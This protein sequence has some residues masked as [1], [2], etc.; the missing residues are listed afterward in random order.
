VLGLVGV[1]N[2][3]GSVD[4]ELRQIEQSIAADR[5]TLEERFFQRKYL[6]PILLAVAIAAFNQLSGINAVLYYSKRIF[7]SAGFGESASLLNSVGLGCVNLVFTIVALF[8]IDRVGRRMLM[9]VG[10]IGY[11]VSLGV[12]AWVFYTQSELLAATDGTIHRELTQR[13]GV[14][15]LMSLI[16]FIASHAVGQGA[17]IWVFLSEIFPTSVRARGQ[18]LGC[19]THWALAAAISQTFPFFAEQSGASI[20]GFYCLCMVGQLI[21]VWLVMPETKGVP[22][23]EIEKRLGIVQ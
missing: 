18:S 15:V 23:E 20:F 6:R 12:T 17:V 4:E 11:I 22:L 16:V 3:A 1:D 9:F 13:G 19:F 2:A 7:D 21:W 10:S 8:L 14:I 5:H